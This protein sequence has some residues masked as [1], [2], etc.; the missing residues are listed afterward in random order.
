MEEVENIKQ[1]LLSDDSKELGL[2][3]GL[4]KS[5]GLVNEVVRYLH[6]HVMKELGKNFWRKIDSY[7]FVVDNKP[8]FEEGFG[9]RIVTS[10]KTR[11]V[12]CTIYGH[13]SY[14]EDKKSLDFVE[15]IHDLI[16]EL[17]K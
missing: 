7:I 4:A 2:G 8:Q 14:V 16:K 1:L 3:L 12:I 15:S 6:H 9:K 10:S 5:L 11:Y 17:T 13:D